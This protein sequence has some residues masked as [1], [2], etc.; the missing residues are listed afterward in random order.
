MVNIE[1]KKKKSINHDENNFGLTLA[2]TET[3]KTFMIKDT[4]EFSSK[5]KE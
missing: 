3:T 4:T 1:K 5:P 2:K